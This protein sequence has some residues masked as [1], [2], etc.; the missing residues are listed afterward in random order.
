MGQLF[1]VEDGTTVSDVC[2]IVLDRR[3]IRPAGTLS[4]SEVQD[5]EEATSIMVLSGA[6]AR[7]IKRVL[8][9]PLYNEERGEMENDLMLFQLDEPVSPNDVQPIAYNTNP[10]L[11]RDEEPVVIMGFGK[12]GPD[13]DP[14]FDLRQA[15]LFATSDNACRGIY[16]NLFAQNIMLCAGDPDNPTSACQG[17][18]GGPLVSVPSEPNEVPVQYGQGKRIVPG[19][20]SKYDNLSNY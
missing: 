1:D 13:E 16:G 14:T 20:N 9:H 10:N 3:V 11:P 2:S 18:S 8:S 19:E 7:N 6:M 17:D 12:T 4:E 5:V 15:D